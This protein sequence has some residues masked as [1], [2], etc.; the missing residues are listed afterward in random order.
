MEDR[1]VELEM[2]TAFLDKTIEELNDV[3]YQQQQQLDQLTKNMELIKEQLRLLTSSLP[4]G[5]RE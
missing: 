4:G 2:K 1:L 3:T 5:L